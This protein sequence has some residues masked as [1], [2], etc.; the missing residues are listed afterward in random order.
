MCGAMGCWCM[1]YGHWDM[2]HLEIHNLTRFCSY[3][4]WCA[5]G[6]LHS[7]S[8]TPT[9]GGVRIKCNAHVM[10]SYRLMC[11]ADVSRSLLNCWR[12]A[13]AS[14]LPLDV[15]GQCMPSWWTAGVGEERKWGLSLL[16]SFHNISQLPP[17]GILI[18]TVDLPP[19]PSAHC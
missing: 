6:C 16:T 5:C 14:L 10:I 17:L 18:L 4:W 11:C 8:D 3:L 1:R 12:N 2:Y 13:T 7:C 19:V 9:I 15:Q